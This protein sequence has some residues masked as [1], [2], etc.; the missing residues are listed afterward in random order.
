MPEE[1][2]KIGDEVEIAA[3]RHGRRGQR[4]V[5]VGITPEG[6]P[7]PFAEVQ[8]ADGLRDGFFVRDLRKSADGDG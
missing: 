7:Q 4:G 1:T 6:H 3:A 2:L 8:F 5:V